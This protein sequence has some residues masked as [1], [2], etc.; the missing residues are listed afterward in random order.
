M[1]TSDPNVDIRRIGE[2]AYTGKYKDVNPSTLLDKYVQLGFKVKDH[3]TIGVEYMWVLV[4]S[5]SCQDDE[6][7]G[8]LVNEPMYLTTFKYG[9]WVPFKLYEI[10]DV[11]EE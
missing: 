2:W 1:K 4:G 9:D 11:F 7:L 5:L 3:P 10:V 6:L 8:T